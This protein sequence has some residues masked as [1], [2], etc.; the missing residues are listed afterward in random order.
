MNLTF[1]FGRFHPSEVRE[2]WLQSLLATRGL[3]SPASPELHGQV[4]V[5]DTRNR[6]YAA[7]WGHD[8]WIYPNK[9]SF[10][11]GVASFSVPLSVATVKS[12]G[13]QSFTLITPYRTFKYAPVYTFTCHLLINCSS[14]FVT[15]PSSHS[16]SVDSS[17]DLSAWMDSLSSTI[18]SALSCSQVALR[19]WENPYNKVCGDCG[20]PNPEWASVNLLLVICHSCA[21]TWQHIMS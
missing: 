1:S 17:K 8:L 2:G 3:Q 11:Q 16:L 7:V 20:A 18:Q 4:Y 21:G 6:A 5:K 14:S 19:L 15:V 9:D 10:L 12:K 13:K